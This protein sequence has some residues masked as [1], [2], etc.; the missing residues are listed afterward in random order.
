MADGPGHGSPPA[1]TLQPVLSALQSPVRREI[2]WM[3]WDAEVAAGDLAAAF[4]LT[5]GTVST[6]LAALRRAG[7]VT[8]RV[9]G[10]FR[11]YR[12]NREAVRGV[13]PLIA[14]G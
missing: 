1:E 14:T 12:A 4:D 8:V 6:H 2:L 10:N 3:V 7:L 5:A 13:L 11:R 9:D